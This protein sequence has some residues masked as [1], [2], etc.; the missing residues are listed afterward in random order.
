MILCMIIV[1]EYLF[2][3]YSLLELLFLNAENCFLVCK[4][5]LAPPVRPLVVGRS[6]GV[7]SYKEKEK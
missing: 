3:D 1:L 2:I 6:V 4:F 5:P 7:G